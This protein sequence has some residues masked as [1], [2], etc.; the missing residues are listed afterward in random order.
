LLI[1]YYEIKLKDYNIED[2]KNYDLQYLLTL[3]III[4]DMALSDSFENMIGSYNIFLMELE[5]IK[6]KKEKK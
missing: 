5:K 3:N 1:E 2:M 6:I 4:E